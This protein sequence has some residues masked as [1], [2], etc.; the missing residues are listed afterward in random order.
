MSQDFGELRVGVNENS[1]RVVYLAKEILLK[2]NSVE[3]YSGTNGAQ[4]VATACEHMVR[5]KY[6]TITDVR[7]ETNIVEGTRRIKFVI[8][9]TK[10]ADFQKIYDENEANRKKKQEEREKA[11]PTPQN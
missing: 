9:L 8:R 7:T 6:V 10:T 1:R 4:T 5:L 11:N 2:N 3:V